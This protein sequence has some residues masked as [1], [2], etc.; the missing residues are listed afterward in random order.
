MPARGGD[1][2]L[3]SVAEYRVYD[4]CMRT[5]T[6]ARGDERSGGETRRAL[7]IGDVSKQ[8]GVGVEALRFYEKAGL[9]ERPART[10][11]GYRLYGAA[12]LE[13]LDFIKRAQV[14]GF[15]LNEIK[16]IID[17]RRAGASPCA[18]VREIVRGRL[19]ELDERMAQMRRYRRELAG[20]LADW[21][22]AGDSEGHVCGLIE[23]SRVGHHP[24]AN[25]FDRA[26]RKGGGK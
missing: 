13:R 3:D 8:S 6:A 23:G 2:G 4:V 1:S 22:A 20:A 14:L 18:N 10:E 24:E 12:T 15:S 17:E 19:R 16:Q 9:L 5:K 7:K 25:G 26:R 11:G 21:D